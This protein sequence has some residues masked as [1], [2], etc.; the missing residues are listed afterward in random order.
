MQKCMVSNKKFLSKEM[1]LTQ[2]FPTSLILRAYLYITSCKTSVHQ[3]TL[4]EMPSSFSVEHWNPKPHP[5]LLMASPLP[6]PLVNS[7][8]KK[9][10][11]FS[12]SE[13]INQIDQTVFQESW[14]F[15]YD[16][17]MDVWWYLSNI[18]NTTQRPGS[19]KEKLTDTDSSLENSNC[20]GGKMISS[21][22][23]YIYLFSYYY[24]YQMKHN[25]VKWDQ[26]P[27]NF[28]WLASLFCTSVPHL[29]N[30]FTS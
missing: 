23:E 8:M 29:S 5:F 9:L 6:V 25:L 2:Y 22:W 17:R 19:N 18:Y 14:V 11:T 15:L 26:I 4:W 13:Y 10:I 12:Q 24:L 20:L 27:E 16:F 30:I 28:G 3:D 7:D 21:P 1:W